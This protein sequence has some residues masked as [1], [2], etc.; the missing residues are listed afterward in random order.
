MRILV[1]EGN[2]PEDTAAMRRYIGGSYGEQYA[3]VLRKLCPDVEIGYAD[4]AAPGWSGLGLGVE[5]GAY[6]GVVWTGSALNMNR[7]HPAI[8]PQISF[9]REVLSSGRSVFGSCWGLQVACVAAGGSVRANPRGREMGL[10]R[11]VRLESAAMEHPMYVGKS[12][13]F[14]TLCCH[15]DEVERM[16][17]GGIVLATNAM[18]EVQAAQ[19]VHGPGV[20]WGVQYHPEFD[21]ALLGHIFRRIGERLVREG[22]FADQEELEQTARDYGSLH[23]NPTDKRLIWRYGVAKE[24]LDSHQRLCELRNW[25]G[26][27]VPDGR[28]VQ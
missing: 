18:S 7:G 14:D 21:F 19:I 20:C 1:V 28:W 11:G 8:A 13:C 24:V 27:L 6:Q 26:N 2:A 10:A 3:G 17:E 16:P 23:C 15:E 9:M 22:F 5:L 4:P 12:R 25:L